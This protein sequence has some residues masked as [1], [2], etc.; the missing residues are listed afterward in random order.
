[1]QM[2]TTIATNYT[3]SVIR[4]LVIRLTT[5]ILGEKNNVP[6]AISIIILQMTII[7]RTS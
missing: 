1:M 3:A 5:V 2:A 7:L 4:T 6:I